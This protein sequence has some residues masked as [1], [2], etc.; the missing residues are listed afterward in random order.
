[1]TIRYG[2]R[3]SGTRLAG[4]AV[5]VAAAFIAV[6]PLYWMVVT[7]LKTSYDLLSS[8]TN[9]FPESVEWGNYVAAWQS[10]NFARQVVNSL[11]VA[12]SVCFV[13]IVSSA[14][15]GYCLARLKPRGGGILFVVFLTT[16]MLPFQ[17]IVVPVFVMLAKVGWINSYQALI[18]PTAANAFGIYLFRQFFV[19][20]P[21]ELEEA[22]RI[23]GASRWTILWKILFPLAR[24]AATTVFLL[25]FVAEWN[26]L[27]KP[28]ILTNSQ[29]MRTVQLGLSVFQEQFL[30]K[31]SLLM[32]AVTIVSL[33]VFG[34]FF[35]AQKR[36]ISA[37]STA[38]LKG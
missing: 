7:S 2:R 26:D 22:A 15:A 14:M 5:L 17:T 8:P 9:L 32:A 6:F 28:L 34:V 31:Y 16:I 33:P 1:M 18:L 25:T 11:F 36:L 3:V 38:G 19:S 23:D 37:F 4:I 13:Q 10:T 27:F 21:V 29:D 12:F 30:V 20:L 35:V 24:P